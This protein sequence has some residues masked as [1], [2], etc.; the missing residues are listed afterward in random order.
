MSSQKSGFAIA[1]IILGIFSFIPGIGVLLG[2]AAVIFGFISLSEIKKKQFTGKGLA[3]GGIFLGFT[4]IAF[5]IVLYS[6][7]FYFAFFAKGGPFEGPKK[8]MDKMM[9]TQTSGYLELYKKKH[10]KY[11]D[12]LKQL[13]ELNG[14]VRTTDFN[15]KPFFYK[16]SPDKQSYDLRSL[17]AD[18]QYG[19]EDDIVAP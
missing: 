10:Q 18:N 2:I 9:L 12:D 6:A 3:K 5:S 8:Q 1:S 14:P 13:I 7:L 4:G 19:T 17:G 11:P 15:F 16:V